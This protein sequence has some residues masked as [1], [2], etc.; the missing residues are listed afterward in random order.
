MMFDTGPTMNFH[1]S[2]FEI[3]ATSPS[4][5]AGSVSMPL[6]MLAHDIDTLFKSVTFVQVLPTSDKDQLPSFIALIE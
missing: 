4:T 6:Q 1:I 5:R 3:L 2:Y